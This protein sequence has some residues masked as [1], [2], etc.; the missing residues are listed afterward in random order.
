MRSVERSSASRLV[1]PLPAEVE[2]L[3]DLPAVL[4]FAARCVCTPHGLLS[5]Q[6]CACVKPLHA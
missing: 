1:A 6:G 2:A 4:G 3:H 5:L